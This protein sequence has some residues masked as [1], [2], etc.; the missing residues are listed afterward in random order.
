MV[1]DVLHRALS[2]LRLNPHKYLQSSRVH[3]PP[4]PGV[5]SRR[6]TPCLPRY[7]PEVVSIYRSPDP[8][9]RRRKGWS[10]SLTATKTS[11]CYLRWDGTYTWDRVPSLNSR[12]NAAGSA[13]TSTSPGRV[14]GTKPTTE[15]AEEEMWL[16]RRQAQL[17]RA[18]RA[19]PG[20]S[21]FGPGHT[22]T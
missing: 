8:P 20:R 9:S 21:A 18:T 17:G 19:C 6:W 4:S 7:L 22:I 5:G 10:L 11:G 12:T 15:G 16:Q 2:R 1:R 3:E 14:G 13:A